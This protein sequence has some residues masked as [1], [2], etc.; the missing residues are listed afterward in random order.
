MNI[1]RFNADATVYVSS[2]T[3]RAAGA[4]GGSL[5]SPGVLPQLRND[6]TIW[7]TADICE[8]CGCTVSGFQCN[9]GL[10]PDPRKVACI[11]NGGP[12]RKVVILGGGGIGNSIL[13][14]KGA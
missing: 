10:R 4:A 12:T 14:A 9:C 6:G 8:A 11:Q 7:T 1:P 5:S 13:Q 2:G 3:Y